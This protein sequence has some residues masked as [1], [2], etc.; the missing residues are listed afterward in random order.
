MATSTSSAK[1]G[2]TVSEPEVPDHDHPHSHPAHRSRVLPTIVGVLSA[3]TCL[4]FMALLTYSVYRHWSLPV[5]QRKDDAWGSLCLM[6]VV[7]AVVTGV[8]TCIMID[9]YA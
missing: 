9:E 2:E 7:G 5:T 8:F 1:G 3:L 6:G 4:A